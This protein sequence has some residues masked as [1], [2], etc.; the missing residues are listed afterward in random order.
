MAIVWHESLFHA[1]ARSKKSVD[2]RFFSYVWPHLPSST[3][4]RTHGT[5]DGV[6]RELRDQVHCENINSQ[7]C[8]DMYKENPS[9]INC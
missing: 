7:I 4:Q 3:G 8:V 5:M 2:M 6:E 9:C 1:G